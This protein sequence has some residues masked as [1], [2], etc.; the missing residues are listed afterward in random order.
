M[1]VWVC[2]C[3]VYVWVCVV[4]RPYLFY[5]A[6]GNAALQAPTLPLLDQ[7]IVE[8]SCTESQPADSFP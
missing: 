6:D 5:S 3:A 4:G 2:V 1:C 7:L 8:F